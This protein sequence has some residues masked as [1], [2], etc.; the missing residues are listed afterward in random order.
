MKVTKTLMDWIRNT[1]TRQRAKQFDSRLYLALYPF[2][3]QV[4]F[5][6]NSKYIVI[7]GK[8]GTGKSTLA[9][10]IAQ[11]I[12]E[13]FTMEKVNLDFFQFHS[14]IT[15]GPRKQA[16]IYDEASTGLLGRTSMTKIATTLIKT[17]QVSRA[18]NLFMLLCIPNFFMIDS[19]IRNHR[20]DALIHIDQ[21]GSYWFYDEHKVKDLLDKGLKNY[22]FKQVK[23]TYMG[24]FTKDLPYP[25]KW[26]DYEAKKHDHMDQILRHMNEELKDK[27]IIQDIKEM[28]NKTL[29]LKEQYE[30]NRKIALSDIAKIVGIKPSTLRLHV[31]QG[32]IVTSRI[33]HYHYVEQDE[34]LR[35][36][37]EKYGVELDGDELRRRL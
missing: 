7:D 36:L 4:Y 26:E 23:P 8:E 6:N 34:A 27:Q 9:I 15:Y 14:Q 2:Y 32:K 30:K 13:Q 10:K 5:H 33:Q 1:I 24:Y 11:T 31:K 35:Y 12:D 17:L 3:A 16:I 21:R 22:N 18:K 25:L 20:V 19:Y 29:L 37:K 28:P